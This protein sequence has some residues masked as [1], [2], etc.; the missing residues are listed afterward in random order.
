ME[1]VLENSDKTAYLEKGVFLD[2]ILLEECVAYVEPHLEEQPEIIVYGKKCKQHRNIGFF[3]DESIGYRYSK[4]L[5]HSKPMSPCMERLLNVINK[6]LD[7]DF[8]GIL[9]NKYMNGNDYIGAHSDDESGLDKVGVV[10]IS[11]G[12]E[13]IFRI[14]DKKTKKI[15]CNEVTTHCSVLHMGGDFQK[16][17]THEIPIQKK[18][19]NSRISFTFRKHI[20]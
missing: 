3:S 1:R 6:T 16:I 20:V 17:Y 19:K 7:A 10:S 18:V 15:I 5:M 13:R 14:R 2:K 4:K 9:V 11:Y 8:N 12:A